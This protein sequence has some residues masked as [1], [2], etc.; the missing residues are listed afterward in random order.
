MFRFLYRSGTVPRAHSIRIGISCA[1]AALLVFSAPAT[2]LAQSGGGYSIDRY[3]IDAGGGRTAS[4]SYEANGTA[5]QPDAAV[6]AGGSYS[7]VGG[8]WLPT[9]AAG[10]PCARSADCAPADDAPGAACTC[11][12]C[13]AGFCTS[14]PIEFGNVNC[15]GPP[16]TVTLDDIL[17]V[18][19]GFGSF[20]SCPNGD[21]APTAGPNACRGNDIINLDDI[22]AVLAAFGGFDPCN[23]QP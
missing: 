14:T 3:T 19:A 10:V 2:S 22:L 13:P 17:C 16:T 11:D 20:A 18:L 21:I 1:L 8:F 5:G 7:V 12:L 6:L 4:A 15:A 23:C 9:A